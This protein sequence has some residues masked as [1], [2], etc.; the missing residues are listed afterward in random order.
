[1]RMHGWKRGQGA[2]VVWFALLTS[3]TLGACGNPSETGRSSYRCE[4]DEALLEERT[5]CF[6]DEQCP[7]GSHCQA[8]LCDYACRTDADCEAARV[9]DAFGRC[10][11][12]ADGLRSRVTPDRGGRLRLRRSFVELDAMRPEGAFA[13]EVE[14]RALGPIRVAA[15]DG[16]RVQC[17]EAPASSECRIDTIVAG[18]PRVVRL[19]LAEIPDEPLSW[20][21][22][23]FAPSERAAVHVRFVEE[24]V[25]L[26]EAPLE[27]V[28]RGEARLEALG[29]L[30]RSVEMP[31]SETLASV[32]FPVELRIHPRRGGRQL[33]TLS[34]EMR[35]LFPSESLVGVLREE[36]GAMTVAHEPV[37]F[38]PNA[39]DSASGLAISGGSGPI[40]RGATG[41][42]FAWTSTLWG[43]SPDASAPYW[44][45]R[46]SLARVGD[47]PDDEPEVVATEAYDAT[48]VASVAVDPLE[49]EAWM[50]SAIPA[51]SGL[52]R[53]Q[54][55]Q[56]LLCTPYGVGGPV[57]FG[58]EPAGWAGELGCGASND[59][60]LAFGV[61][62]E[63][64]WRPD[65][66]V[67]SC[68]SD[69]DAL[70]DMGGAADRDCV[71][72]RRTVAA[73]V[74][75]L[76]AD[77]RRAIGEPVASDVAASAL[78]GRIVDRWIGLLA[79]V[80][81][82][83]NQLDRLADIVGP[84]AGGALSSSPSDRL[85]ALV[86]G[87][88]VLFQPRISVGWTTLNASS[89][90]AP[91]YRPYFTGISFSDDVSQDRFVAL[92]V[93][94][95]VGL[96][97]LVRAATVMVQRAHFDPAERRSLDDVGR[98]LVR[99]VLLGTVAASNLVL[100]ARA[101]SSE[102]LAWLDD[103]ERGLGRLGRA[104]AA[105]E[106]ALRAL[107]GG[108]NPL[109]IDPELDLPLYRIGD[110]DAV[111]SRFSSLSDYFVGLAGTDEGVANAAVV[112]AEQ[113]LE[114][115][116]GAW[117]DNLLRDFRE[118]VQQAASDRRMEAIQRRYGEQVASLCGDPD[119]DARTVLEQA[120][121]IDADECF[122]RSRCRAGLSRRLIE[123][124]PEEVAFDL[125]LAERARRALGTT[126]AGPL[127]AS[128]YDPRDLRDLVD[129]TAE[130]VGHTVEGERSR[131]QF[132]DGR[133]VE[134]DGR[135]LTFA[136]D[137]SL[138]A[139]LAAE[140]VEA[141]QRACSA[142]ASASAARRPIEPPDRCE[143]HGDCPVGYLCTDSRCEPRTGG[144]DDPT[145]F[146]GALG[147]VAVSMRAASLDVRAAR[148]RLDEM[149]AAYD[150]AM[151]SCI[152]SWLGDQEQLRALEAHNATV[153]TLAKVKLA[154][155]VAGN[156]A[157]ATK[158][159]ATAVDVVDDAV[160]F[161][162]AGGIACG[163]AA[164]Q[165]VAQSVSDGMQFAIDE[166]ERQ[167][168]VTSARIEA[169]TDYARCVT[170]AESNLV[171]VQ[172]A[173]LEIAAA[174]EEL[175]GLLV[176]F[177][178]LKVDVRAALAEGADALRRE[179]E[180]TIRPM[181]IDFWLDERV[182]AY[183]A[184]MRSARRALFLAVLAV[185]YEYQMS[186]AERAA[187]L[188][189]R[190]VSELRGVLDRLRAF[191]ATGTVAGASPAEM[192]A[193]VSLRDHLLALT[194]Q[195]ERPAGWHRM[196]ER[197]RFRALLLDPRFAVYNRSGRYTGQRIPFRIVPSGELGLGATGGIPLL[198]G[199]DCAE[200]VWSVGASLVGE[201]VLKGQ[202]TLRTRIV[203]EKRNRFFSQWCDGRSE[204]VFQYRAT[205]PSRNLL[206]DPLADFSGVASGVGGS[207]REAAESD[208]FARARLQPLV[209]MSAAD[210]DEVDV[211]PGASRELAGRGLY[212]E[213]ALFLPVEF[214]A[215]EERDGIDL[216]AVDDVLLR[217]DYVSVA[218]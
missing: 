128:G 66:V 98:R 74:L 162:V 71:D 170:E 32:R 218:R 133:V 125:C 26:G 2:L 164:V 115:A 79:F 202:S 151:R 155:D 67:A 166:A 159:C 198:T 140:E 49:A 11:E 36:D 81:K 163:A 91:D 188:E 85:A 114:M 197:E 19:S 24:Q 82:Q 112:R 107:R 178:N 160:S 65:S 139:E 181:E 109:G 5:S 195:S 134:V 69:L 97:E 117:A 38:L 143:W 99:R 194:D 177:G 127:L 158:D 145:C 144:S 63:S 15:P 75:A 101:Q 185:E 110:E 182:E 211:V 130:V 203:I 8:G 191:V 37:R 212:G 209:G 201:D 135:L 141:M 103:W 7:C 215:D 108:S 124:A 21:V 48:N 43:L 50:A 217:I 199:L 149:S 173:A 174:T 119:F 54:R 25:E 20:S 100:R 45:W 137:V 165:Q 40:Q 123:R 9:C 29:T 206:A 168:E 148:S 210:L 87:L 55:L 183:E 52:G 118:E 126:A 13:I 27:G 92:P 176:T 44:V 113:A 106:G 154:A 17:D 86:E 56:A 186:S 39:G 179:R 200:R 89:L 169:R 77:R 68:L 146:M 157:E 147:E 88:D 41:L 175:A 196:S 61:L 22:R 78:G 42:G 213:Y 59:P 3:W 208:A 30:A 1:M 102:P 58:N 180:R 207:F 47:L 204:P 84:S 192:H 190:S 216:A 189:S 161:G 171:G 136:S 129:G 18:S 214:L 12:P 60:Q 28:Y 95:V 46:V 150:I 205:R 104:L 156:A 76:D 16:L 193:V 62:G 80:A 51:L 14:G 83:S 167:H 184:S 23:I 121:S 72:A 93:A 33:V 105:F 153:S 31:V 138:P 152:V 35:A 34:D 96:D 116:R 10:V 73:M 94:I 70:A 120:A 6:S 132:A 122:L 142:V 111:G 131:V 57:L 4:V 172:T 187:V 90:R 53:Q 64:S